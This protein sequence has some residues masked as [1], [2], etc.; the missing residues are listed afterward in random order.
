[1]R[2]FLGVDVGGTKSHALVADETGQVSG[3]GVAGPGNWEMVGWDGAKSVLQ[4]IVAQACH[5]AAIHPSQISGAGFGLAGHDWPEDHEPHGRLIESLGL[6][7]PYACGNDALVGLM[8][9]ARA[10]WGVVIVA[11][12]S[13]NCRGRTPDGREGRITGSSWFGEYAGAGELVAEA[14]RAVARAW[15]YR[16]PATALS[17]ILVEHV[18][19]ADVTDLLAGL[20]RDRYSLGAEHAHLVFQAAAAGDTV[21]HDLITWA[22]QELGGSAN[23]IIRQLDIAHLPFEVVLSGSFFNGSPHLVETVR[24]TIQTVAPQASL[25][26]L[27]APPV[28]GGVLWGMQ[29]AGWNAAACR[30]TLI[31]TSK[32][33]FG[34][35]VGGSE[36]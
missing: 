30:D 29:V 34:D 28:V 21:A 5:A 9:G 17:N 15:S 22:G 7:G 16:A 27:A 3:L 8:A 24:Q 12:T 1:M 25:V 13:N 6:N 11:G 36:Q 2:Y 23:G 35:K 32:A 4:T 33:F 14:V 26:R 20:M 31:A 19:A 18:G 10:G